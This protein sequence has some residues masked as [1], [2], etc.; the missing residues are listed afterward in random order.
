M[1]EAKAHPCADGLTPLCFKEYP[2]W[3]RRALAYKLLHILLPKQLSKLLPRGLGEAFIGDDAVLPPG[4]IL[5]PGVI[6]PPGFEWPASW[7][8]YEEFLASGLTVPWILMEWP[9][10]PGSPPIY[11][12][13][14][15]PGPV[16]I[17]GRIQNPGLYSNEIMGEGGIGDA[18]LNWG[19]D[20][21]RVGFSG[22]ARTNY[23]C[24]IKSI[25][26]KLGRVGSPV[27]NVQIGIYNAGGD[28]KP[29]TLVSGGA[30]TAIGGA[31]FDGFSVGMSYYQFD[32]PGKPYLTSGAD[33]FIGM[34]RSGG[35]DVSNY[36]GLVVGSDPYGA[37]Y[38][39]DD[40]G[41]WLD[42]LPYFIDYQ[43]WGYKV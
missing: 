2:S 5:P 13:P 17:P 40:L 22:V 8:T 30:A 3:A 14:W 9:G 15:E 31:S 12:Q 35:Y 26:L 10:I 36:Y 21:T 20:S 39:Q 4:L 37:C 34:T 19:D 7:G 23:N 24:R 41:V 27:D 29:S 28:N 16:V 25:K 38:Y 18:G 6:I 11:V 43:L 1:V 42:M 33:Y 32:F